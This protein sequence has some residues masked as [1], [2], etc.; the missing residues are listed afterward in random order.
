MRAVPVSRLALAISLS[1]ATTSALAAPQNFLTARSFAMGGTGVA[2]A[3][4][5]A[6]NSA[7]PA[8][9]AADHHAWSDDF[10]LILPSVN[11]RVADD[12]D[13][14][15]QIDD[16]QTTIDRIDDAINTLDT[17]GAQAGAA[18]LRRQ[19]QDF[20]KD[21]MRVD[22]GL[23]ISLAIPNNTLSV[24]FFTQGSLRATVRGEYDDND[25]ALLAAIENGALN[26][27]F[28][29]QLQSRGSI[30]ASAV[31]EVG[32]SF[33]RTVTL[34]DN[35]SLQLGVSP[36]YVELRTFQY[37]ETVSGFDDNDFDASTY[38]TSKS[39]L[40][41]DIGAA[42][43][44]GTEQQWN[45][46]AAVRNIIPMDLDSA[47]T[48]PEL[49]EEVRTLELKPQLTVGIAHASEYHVVTAELDLTK[50]QAFGY[51]DDTQWL[52][53]GAEFDALRYAQLRIGVRQNLA[54]NNGNKGVE[55]STQL[56]AGLGLNPFGARLDIGALVSDAE[57]G[58]ALEFGVAF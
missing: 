18:D 26:P 42:Y 12:E 49:G 21:T 3:H 56:T 58:A 14:V 23:G 35:R 22:A 30:L 46:G 55:E 37:T 57:F 25:D 10:G 9:L 41:F 54:D 24:G 51:E 31:A 15:D 38:E 17:A 52:A 19:L 20:D 27:G 2:I 53:L 48:R 32:L 8:M 50:Q 47:A 7:N 29:D 13:T 36:K 39:G 4:P 11:A 28:A 16:M 5:A 33:A 34:Q 45:L 6:A 40:N 43:R 1:A 44:F